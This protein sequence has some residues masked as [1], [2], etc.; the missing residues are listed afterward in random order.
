MRQKKREFHSSELVQ[1]L[2]KIYGFDDVLTSFKI[3]DFLQEYLDESLFS[4]LELIEYRQ[5]ILKLKI[6]SPLLKNDFQLRKSFYLKKI[7]ER[8]EN[9]QL[10]DIVI[11]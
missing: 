1:K 2:A 9:L 10:S 11:I 8:V 3:K 7:S 6:K 4:E 5:K